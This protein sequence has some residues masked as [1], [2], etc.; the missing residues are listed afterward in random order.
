VTT[1]AGAPNDPVIVLSYAYAGAERV[2]AALAA[3]SRLA[4]TSG[5]G[6]IPQCDVIAETWRR[7]EGQQGSTMSRVATAAIRGIVTAQVTAILASSGQPQW[8]ELSTGSPGAAETFLQVFPQTRFVCVH[9][10]CLDVVRAGVQA[11]PWGLQGQGFMPFLLAYPGNSVAALAAHWLTSTEQLLTFERANHQAAHRVRYEDATTQPDQALAAVRAVLGLGRQEGNGGFP[12]QPWRLT[13]P[14]G[15]AAEPD[16][17]VPSEM[18]PEPLR[19]RI[20]HVHAELG[21][22]QL[23]ST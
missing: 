9:R 11:S 10:S 20:S 1:S 14:G 19:Q 22:P 8:C 4:R 6:I 7:I 12:A 21:Y 16:A 5:T 23:Q 15:G 3:D 13:E 2:Q 18:I 17:R